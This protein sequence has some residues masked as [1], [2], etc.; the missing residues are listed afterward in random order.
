MKS[1]MI[2]GRRRFAM[3]FRSSILMA[4]SIRLM[5]VSS[6]SYARRTKVANT[7]RQA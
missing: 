5:Y 3:R 4:L 1:N 6:P 7:S 2:F